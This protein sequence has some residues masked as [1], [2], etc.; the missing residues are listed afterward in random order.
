MQYKAKGL[1]AYLVL[2][3]SSSMRA[4][5]KLLNDTLLSIYDT[6]FTSPQTSEFIHLSVMSFNTQ[7]YLVTPMTDIE[8]L[9][10]LPT[11]TCEGLSNFG[12]MFRLVR[13]R[14]TEDIQQLTSSGTQVLR[15]V[16]FLLTDGIPTDK[17]AGIWQRDLDSLRDPTFKAHPNIITY[18]FGDAREVVLRRIST[19]AAYLADDEGGHTAE[20][21][22]AALSSLLNSLVASAR[23]R[24]LQVPEEVKGYK[25]VDLD[26]LD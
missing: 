10:D 1:P 12:P 4:F 9:Q 21:L 18:G 13:D 2:D 8:Q 20:A 24:Q 14:I 19:L 7:S 25:T 11:V 17:P 3:T 16:V 26:F 22:G 15:P 6:L 5:E 23:V